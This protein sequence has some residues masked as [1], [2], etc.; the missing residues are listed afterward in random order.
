[1]QKTQ[2]EPAELWASALT[3]FSQRA[4]LLSIQPNAGDRLQAQHLE[5]ARGCNEFQAACRYVMPVQPGLLHKS[6]G[7]FGKSTGLIS[8]RTRSRARLPHISIS[9]VV[10]I[11]TRHQE[12]A[13]AAF[14]GA[15]AISRF[16]ASAEFGLA[17]SLQ[18]L[19]QE[20]S[21]GTPCAFS[22][23]DTDQT[24]CSDELT[25]WRPGS[26]FVGDSGAGGPQTA[27]RLSA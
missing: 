7:D 8:T 1:V 10:A 9:S 18:R 19:G 3:S 14:G 24:G 11:A 17:R 21:E 27:P 25:L 2:V 5:H 12:E 26:S 22:A 20:K 16:H 6:Q 15:L 13:I 4:T 23:P